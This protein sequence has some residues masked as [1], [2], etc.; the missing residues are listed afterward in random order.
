M[1][2]VQNNDSDG[3]WA[4]HR[5]AFLNGNFRPATRRAY[6]QAI[7]EFLAEYT[8]DDRAVVAWRVGLLQRG[9]SRR[10][11]NCKLA[12]LRGFFDHLVENGHLAGNPLT[13]SGVRPF[14]LR[15]NSVREIPTHD[16]IQALLASCEDGTVAGARDRTIIMLAAFEG[17]NRGRIVALTYESIDRM[18]IEP[19]IREALA[20]WQDAA[21]APSNG[22]TPLF[23]SLSNNGNGRLSG[24]TVNLIIK[25]RARR[26]GLNGITPRTLRRYRNGR[27]G[28]RP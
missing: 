14:P 5:D 27:E 2:W 17:L 20:A 16:Q 1:G 19:R 11:V 7:N 4:H 10:T 28:R 15:R 8:I 9:N 6:R 13:R 12:A 18:T 22:R 23:R 21:P 24:F 3:A 26:A 25:K